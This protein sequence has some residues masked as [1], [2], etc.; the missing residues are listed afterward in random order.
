MLSAV[1]GF[2]LFQFC[3][4]GPV[5]KNENYRIKSIHTE[6]ERMRRYGTHCMCDRLHVRKQNEHVMPMAETG[7]DQN[8]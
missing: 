8:G 7:T 2:G 1:T 5:I 6:G 4:K 3:L